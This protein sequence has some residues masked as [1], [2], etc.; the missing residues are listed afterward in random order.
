MLGI[1]DPWILSA[2]LLCL[3]STAICVVYGLLCWNKGAETEPQQE[4]KAWAQE[5]DEI[6]ES[7]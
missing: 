3:L 1:K 2:Y 6:A 7:L 4:D 5:E